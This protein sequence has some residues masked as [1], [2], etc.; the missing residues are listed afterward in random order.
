MKKMGGWKKTVVLGVL[1][2]V[3]LFGAGCATMDK[4]EMGAAG[5]AGVG[6]LVGQAI[7]Y[8]TA[9]TLI[10]A[11][12][13]LGLGYIIGNEADKADAS[14]RKKATHEEVQPLANTTWQVV[15][16]TPR[17]KKHY[18]SM[19][20]RFNQDGTVTTTTTLANG[21]VETDTESYR[22]VGATL[23]INKPNYVINSRYRI[24]GSKMYMD[25]GDHS[26]VLQRVGS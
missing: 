24:D 15:S 19:I 10:G 7:G 1:C 13:G 6:A 9:G 26:I 14:K 11:G 12:V 5:G 16:V 21:R 2:T 22:V 4:S 18:Q 3:L 23:V 17:P 20:T 25:T 8:N